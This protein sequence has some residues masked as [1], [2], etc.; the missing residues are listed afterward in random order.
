MADVQAPTSGVETSPPRSTSLDRTRQARPSGAM[1]HRGPVVNAWADGV[2]ASP[3]TPRPHQSELRTVGLAVSELQRLCAE[4]RR[5][6]QRQ[7]DSFDRRLQEHLAAPAASREKWANLQGS[8]SGL[9]EE[10]ASLVRR[11]ETLDEKLRIR[12]ASCEEL[13]RQRSR[14]LEQQ[15]HGQQQKVQ[16][17]VSTFEEMSKRQTAKLRKVSQSTEEQAR[18][19]VALED[20]VRRAQGGHTSPLEAMQARLAELE[21]Q[22]ASLEEEFRHV[23]ASSAIAQAM[24]PTHA[25]PLDEDYEG[26]RVAARA[27]ESELATLS[28]QLASQLDEHSAALANLRV[29]TES[30][31]Q[32]LT[33]AGD[34]LEKVV[35]PTV[36]A[37][38]NEMQQLRLADRSE[39]EQQLEHF[40]RQLKELADSNEEA[41]SEVREHVQVRAAELQRIREACLMQEQAQRFVAMDPP[42]RE[43]EINEVLLRVERL[44]NQLETFNHEPVN[45]KADRADVHRLDLQLQELEQPL[46]RLSQRTASNEARTTGLEHKLEQFQESKGQDGSKNQSR[47]AQ[48]PPGDLKADG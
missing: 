37:V 41:L 36:E 13:L 44:E 19:M 24:T 22:Q 12:T 35:A 15:L 21:G 31:E 28:K 2:M 6:M 40:T 43:E 26:Q 4:D 27:L 18:K 45:E 33:A 7:L 46:R 17:A 20:T 11:V 14:E 9:L 1:T 16:L 34:R 25:A 5:V 38:R 8:V 30:Q 23:A 10:V 29:R 32:R 39:I 3:R 42:Q 48:F 47:R